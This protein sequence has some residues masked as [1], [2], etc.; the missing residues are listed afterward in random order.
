MVGWHH[1]LNGH[2]FEETL[3]VDDGQGGHE[4]SSPWG[5]KQS[6]MT[7]QLN[8]NDGHLIFDKGGK[9]IQCRK[10]NLFNKCWQ[11]WSVTCKRMKLEHFLTPFPKIKWIKDLQVRPEAINHLEENMQNTFWHKS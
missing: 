10:D 9:N 4:C 1:Q 6:D 5:P 7:E 3:G 11:K 8:R 2:E